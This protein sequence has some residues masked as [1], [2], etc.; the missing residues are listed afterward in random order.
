MHLGQLEKSAGAARRQ[1][2]GFGNNGD[3]TAQTG[4]AGQPNA[5]G[6][7]TDAALRNAFNLSGGVLDKADAQKVAAVAQANGVNVTPEHV[8]Q[9]WSE[10]NAENDARVAAE[11][12]AAANQAVDP[13]VAARQRRED[14]QN[15]GLYINPYTDEVFPAG[16]YDRPTE[17]QLAN[18]KIYTSKWGK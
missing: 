16:P 5:G 11:A 18:M 15:L 8:E 6:L 13:G 2:W 7:F 1:R 4:P 3:G 9:Q 17:Q 14:A 12:E 10:Q